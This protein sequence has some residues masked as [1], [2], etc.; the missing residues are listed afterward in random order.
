MFRIGNWALKTDAGCS[1]GGPMDERN[2]R[3]SKFSR[4]PIKQHSGDYRPPQ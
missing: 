2:K 3:I 4:Q 1:V